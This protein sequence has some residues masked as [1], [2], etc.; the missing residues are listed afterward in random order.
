[1]IV[2][3]SLMRITDRR[4]DAAAQQDQNGDDPRGCERALAHGPPSGAF[5]VTIRA[6]SGGCGFR[7]LGGRR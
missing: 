2:V 5:A 7:F 1:M 4:R 3:G 6:D